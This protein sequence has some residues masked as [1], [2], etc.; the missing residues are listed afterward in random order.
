MTAEKGNASCM[1]VAAIQ[2]FQFP[3]HEQGG[4]LCRE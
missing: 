2:I 4:G 3:F 1:E